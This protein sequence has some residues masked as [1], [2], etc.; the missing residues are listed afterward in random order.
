VLGTASILKPNCGARVAPEKP[1]VF[2]QTVLD[3][4]DDRERAAKLSAQARIYA[5]SWASANMAWRL[6]ELYREITNAGS[7]RS[8][9]SQS[10]AG[11]AA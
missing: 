11:A 3:V 6:A 10:A 7:A 9:N 2:A 8:P 5:Q 4:L 1:D